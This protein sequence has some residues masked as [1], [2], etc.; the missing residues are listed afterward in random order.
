MLH[1]Y[2]ILDADSHVFEPTQMWAKYLSPEF[3]QFAPSPDM[4]IQGKKITNQV[5]EQVEKEG[6]KQM[7]TSHPN[8][9]LK[10]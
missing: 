3:K 4:R 8:A 5:S 9:Y 2:K 6:N 10:Q 7:M 1:G